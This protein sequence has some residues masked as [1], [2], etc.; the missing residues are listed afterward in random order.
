[1]YGLI[2]ETRNF[3]PP[4]I[5]LLPVSSVAK[6]R[7]GGGLVN[8]TPQLLSYAVARM[9]VLRECVIFDLRTRVKKSA[10][11]LAKTVCDARYTSLQYT[12]SLILVCKL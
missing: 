11:S 4:L 12:V 5:P 10:A 6:R 9:R 7:R 2:L 1:M 3:P 8:W